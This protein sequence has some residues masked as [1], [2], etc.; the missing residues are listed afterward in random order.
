MPPDHFDSDWLN[1]REPADHAARSTALE[2]LLIDALAQQ[3]RPWRIV[4]LGAGTGSNPRHLAP[5]LPGPQSWRLVDHDAELLER[6]RTDLAAQDHPE[7]YALR[8]TTDR[9]AL[10]PIDDVLTGGCHLVTASALIDL[11]SADWLDALAER[12]A[13]IS[14]CVL[15]TL[16]IDGRWRFLPTGAGDTHDESEDARMRTLYRQH[17]ARDKGLGQALGGAAP[18]RL[19]AA[20]RER[21]FDVTLAPSPWRLTTDRDVPLARALLSGWREA[22]C[23]QAPEQ[24]AAIEAWAAARDAD[25][26][27]GALGVEVGHIDLFGRPA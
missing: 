16:S 20:L 12:A 21:G 4:D 27:R 24:S 19:A 26:V 10:D 2:A 5:R 9:R 8:F 17:Q 18:D 25:L 1:L 11:V 6:A 14:A 23:A 22:L 15:V 13:A 7:G 3:R